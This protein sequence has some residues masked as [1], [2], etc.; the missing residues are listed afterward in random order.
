MQSCTLPCIQTAHCTKNN[1]QIFDFQG[2]VAQKCKD[3]WQMWEVGQA[4]KK[5]CYG[6]FSSSCLFCTFSILHIND[7]NLHLSSAYQHI[8]TEF[9]LANN[10]GFVVY[11]RTDLS[12]C[13]R[14]SIGPDL[15]VLVQPS[16]GPKSLFDVKTVTEFIYSS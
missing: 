9:T 8:W 11:S 5:K 10:C 16:G 4:K 2:S 14:S 12:W 1:V 3:R 7:P 15:H 13:S 6:C